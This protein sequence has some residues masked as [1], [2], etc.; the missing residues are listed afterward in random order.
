MIADVDE[1]IEE[2]TLLD[3]HLH[4]VFLEVVAGDLS[5]ADILAHV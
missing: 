3:L 4:A 2:P 5:T 1:V